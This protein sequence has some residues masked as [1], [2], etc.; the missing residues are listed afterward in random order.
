MGLMS[1]FV[2]P[3]LSHPQK[4]PLHNSKS[5]NK[6]PI[7]KI[8]RLLDPKSK[9]KQ[10]LIFGGK[11]AYNKIIQNC[12]AHLSQA[13]NGVASHTNFQDRVEFRG[14]PKVSSE[15]DYLWFLEI[16]LK[17]YQSAFEQIS[18][19]FDKNTWVLVINLL[20]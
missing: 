5:N 18:M 11:A 10:T 16:V 9:G 19:H 15:Y 20:I 2:R 7:K 12:F 6:P 4:N 14:S 8:R 13:F 3:Q 1:Y 17:T